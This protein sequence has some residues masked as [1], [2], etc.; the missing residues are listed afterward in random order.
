[1]RP[2]LNT[3]RAAWRLAKGY[4]T[5]EEKWSGWGLLVAVITLNLGNVYISVQINEWNKAFYNALQGFNRGEMFRQLV[6]FCI[7]AVSYTHL[8]LPTICSV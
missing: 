6:V 7:L 2:T 8:T 1:M 4:W 3:T 5:S